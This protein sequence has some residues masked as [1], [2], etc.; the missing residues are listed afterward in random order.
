[1]LR[2]TLEGAF[3]PDGATRGMKALLVRAGDAPDFA[4]LEVQ[5]AETETQV[6]AIFDRLIP[7]QDGSST[8]ASG[9]QVT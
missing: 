1:M 2:I 8:S 5:L 7:V 9:S 3:K 6:R 4:A